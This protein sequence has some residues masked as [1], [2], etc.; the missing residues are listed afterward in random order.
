[1]HGEAVVFA[2]NA[3]MWHL[4]CPD[5]TSSVFA[6]ASRSQSF[7]P[8]I[9]NERHYLVEGGP[10]GFYRYFIVAVRGKFPRTLRDH[11]RAANPL[12]QAKLDVIADMILSGDVIYAVSGA[13]MRVTN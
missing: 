6:I 11:L 10:T 3:G 7:P 12:T 9:G 5:E 2:E 1:M 8:Q 4:I 13:T